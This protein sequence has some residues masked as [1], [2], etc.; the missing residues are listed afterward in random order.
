MN[1]VASQLRTVLLEFKTLCPASFLL[2]P[3]I[4]L[5]SFRALKPN[6]LTHGKSLFRIRLINQKAADSRKPETGSRHQRRQPTSK[7][8]QK[9]G[10]Q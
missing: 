5:S 7:S 6:V 8:A 10:R 4:P 3:V 9:E 2:D 1:R